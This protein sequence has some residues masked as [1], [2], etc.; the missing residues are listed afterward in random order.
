MYKIIRWE[1]DKNTEDKNEIFCAVEIEDAE[2]GTYQFAQWF[3]PFETAELLSN[4]EKKNEYIEMELTKAK[5]F[6]L[7]E[8]EYLK[9][10]PPEELENDG[11]PTIYT[12]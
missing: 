4:P 7:E 12:S 2:L 11:T 9:N 8:I 6:K 5:Q 3:T 10:N 1:I